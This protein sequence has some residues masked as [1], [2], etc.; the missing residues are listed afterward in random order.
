[1]GVIDNFKSDGEYRANKPALFELAHGKTGTWMRKLIIKVKP[2]T[3]AL[4]EARLVREFGA[5]TKDWNADV[6][7]MENQRKNTQNITLIPI[8][9]FLIVVTFL[10]INVALGLFGVLNVSITKR[11]GEIG[12]RRAL[13]ATESAISWQ[14]VAEIWTLSTFAL[15]IGV[16]LA[17]QF[18]LLNVFDLNAGVYLLAMV[19]SAVVI[20]GLVTVCALYPGLLASRMQPALAL[21]EE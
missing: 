16:L 18:P 14:I 4:V 13:G 20:Y 5:I 6:S 1:V 11:R 2:G 21:H 19:I 9:I 17:G 7:Y 8:A 3:D 12:L 10:L 15:I